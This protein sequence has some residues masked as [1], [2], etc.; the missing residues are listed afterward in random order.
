MIKNTTFIINDVLREH[1]KDDQSSDQSYRNVLSVAKIINLNSE[2][3]VDRIYENSKRFSEKYAS[4]IRHSSLR[5]P[6]DREKF[7]SLMC[8]D[9]EM[10]A[11]VANLLNSLNINK[12]PNG[13]VF[14]YVRMT[15]SQR[16]NKSSLIVF[17][18]INSLIIFS[19]CEYLQVKPYT[20]FDL[21]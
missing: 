20:L 21:I 13:S 9:N 19:C 2:E 15:E 3:I 14:G 5:I 12:L 8:I 17:T 16:M 4:N 7:N 18:F 1:L 6:L 10:E 11:D